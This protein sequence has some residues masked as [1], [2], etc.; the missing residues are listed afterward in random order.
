MTAIA[1]AA[2]GHWA[3]D[4]GAS[5]AGWVR[6]DQRMLTRVGCVLPLGRSPL[7]PVSC[8]NHGCTRC[9]IFA[10]HPWVLACR[11]RTWPWP[12]SITRTYQAPGPRARHRRRRPSLPLMLVP[13]CV[14]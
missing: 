14:A 8:R 12:P 11:W 3:M 1:A 2:G 13:L 5:C 10:L 4:R 6:E 9:R 7:A